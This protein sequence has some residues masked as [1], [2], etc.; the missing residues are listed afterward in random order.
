MRGVRT[1]SCAR[2]RR[3]AMIAVLLGLPYNAEERAR[4]E[5]RSCSAQHAVL[6]AHASELRHV[7]FSELKR[8]VRVISSTPVS[9]LCRDVV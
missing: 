7:P 8:T 6:R 5:A 3:E 2:R 1:A 4:R 9:F